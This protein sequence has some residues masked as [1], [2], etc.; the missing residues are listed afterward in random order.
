MDCQ[1]CRKKDKQIESAVDLIQ[2]L[3]RKIE[4]SNQAIEILNLKVKEQDVTIV[5]LNNGLMTAAKVQRVNK[6]REQ[7]KA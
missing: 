7:F 5:K 4:E 2:Q 1:E 3:T 6:F